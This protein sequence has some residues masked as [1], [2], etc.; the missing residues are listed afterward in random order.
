MFELFLNPSQLNSN[1]IR[2]GEKR[3]VTQKI[4]YFNAN[5]TLYQP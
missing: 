5:H 2:A 1:K 3:Y 4:F